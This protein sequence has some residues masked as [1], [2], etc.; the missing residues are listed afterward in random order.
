MEH[1]WLFSQKGFSKLSH[2]GKN[3]RLPSLVASRPRTAS[4]PLVPL[5]AA[6]SRLSGRTGHVVSVRDL[7]RQSVHCDLDPVLYA[8]R[9]HL[10]GQSP[11]PSRGGL[12]RT[13][14]MGVCSV[15]LQNS[16]IPLFFIQYHVSEK[17][18]ND[19]IINRPIRVSY[20]SS[21]CGLSHQIFIRN[22]DLEKLNNLP[23]VTLLL[24]R[25]ARFEPRESSRRVLVI[26]LLD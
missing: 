14:N 7:S 11:E 23:R 17:Q 10:D 16:F 3:Q 26:Y 20:P 4:E 25:K 19:D 5:T 6:G 24:R 1:W 9:S 2:I 13:W 18:A 21:L 8:H 15:F 12:L 22:W